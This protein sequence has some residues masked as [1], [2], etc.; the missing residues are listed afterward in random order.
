MSAMRTK[1]GCVAP[2]HRLDLALGMILLSALSLLTAKKF[3]SPA[4]R[5]PDGVR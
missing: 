2:R 5:G 1:L 4:E 3:L